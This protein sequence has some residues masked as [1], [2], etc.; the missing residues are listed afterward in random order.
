MP[1]NRL[2][3]IPSKEC[4]QEGTTSLLCKT[5]DRAKQITKQRNNDFGGYP[6]LKR[7]TFYSANGTGYSISS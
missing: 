1:S 7:A 3:L 2:I 4:L 5:H 6:K